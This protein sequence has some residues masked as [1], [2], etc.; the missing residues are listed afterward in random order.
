MS[1][2]RGYNHKKYW[3]RRKIVVDPNNKTPL[4]IKIYYLWYIKRKDVR[5]GCSFGTNLNS[6]SIFVSPPHLPHGP[7]GIICGH[8]WKV[9]KNC[10]L[11]HH[12]TLAGGGIIGDNCMI[13]A[14]AKILNNVKIGN[15]VKVGLNAVVVEDIPDNTTVV[16]QKP[17]IITH[18]IGG[19]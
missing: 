1:V 18:S 2:L 11:F 5:F 19:G 7:Y 12:V 9:G 6:G 3:R 8:D 14:G 15:N 16:L 4:L 13:G 10:T 17:R